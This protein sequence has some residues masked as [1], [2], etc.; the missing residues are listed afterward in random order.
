MLRT[1]IID[2]DKSNEIVCNLLDSG[3]PFTITRIGNGE[4][5][6]ALDILNK[7][8]P[9]QQRMYELDN[10]AGIYY[11]TKQHLELF[12]KY[13]N[14]AALESDAMACFDQIYTVQQNE[15]LKRSP[16]PSLHFEVLEPYYS[17]EKGIVPW[18]H[19]LIGKKILIIS[20]FVE[21]YKK[22]VEL[23]FHFYGPDS[24]DE[25]RIFHKDQQF[26][27]YKT[28]STLGGNHIHNSWYQTFGIMC[29]D[30]KALDF[31]IALVSC[32]G[33]GLPLCNYIKSLGKSAI[34]VGGALQLLFGVNGQR[35]Q[36]HPVIS[37]VSSIHGNKWTWP[38]ESETIK[39]NR[40]IEGGCYWK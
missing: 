5:I 26:V 8:Q 12:A 35:W 9:N 36:A 38:S 17:I 1:E 34:Y 18:S 10:N 37:R 14:N 28:Y 25:K 24:P 31:D 19:K 15:Y 6:V 4:S 3:K 23:G 22:Q 2:L 16:K 30:I 11:S 27:F 20:P 33:Y 29:N 39:T 21:T 13:Y 32:G 40:K 7:R